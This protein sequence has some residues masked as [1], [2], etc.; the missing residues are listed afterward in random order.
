MRLQENIVSE[1]WRNDVSD[2][3][4]NTQPD[5]VRDETT[6]ATDKEGSRGCSAVDAAHVR[7]REQLR[8]AIEVTNESNNGLVACCKTLE[9]FDRIVPELTRRIAQR[10]G[11]ETQLAGL[12]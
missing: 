11:M 4:K 10:I 3:E 7:L 12:G 9:D 1:P 8:I 5:H 6:N 2:S